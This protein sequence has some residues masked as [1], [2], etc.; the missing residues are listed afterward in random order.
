MEPTGRQRI[1]FVHVDRPAKLDQKQAREIRSHAAR[2]THARAR[3][4]R[5]IAHL[6]LPDPRQD[7]P[8]PAI[9]ESTQEEIAKDK[10]N[11]SEPMS[12]LPASRKDPFAAF[13]R[14][15]E[16][17]EHFLLDHCMSC[18]TIAA[19]H[20]AANSILADVRVVIPL[21]STTCKAF[22]SA[23]E[24][25][26]YGRRMITDW[27]PFAL[28]D[29]GL[30]SGMFLAACRDLSLSDHPRKSVFSTMALQYKLACLGAL[31]SAISTDPSAPDD[32][33]VAKVI[34]LVSDEVSQTPLVI[35]NPLQLRKC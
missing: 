35:R 33:A 26:H 12:L 15:L 31:K 25:A 30:L 20:V 23:M 11:T 7:P 2:E 32:A 3:R 29:I 24:G 9:L 22:K 14:S 1:R 16:P 28:A 5:V 18:C 4:L 21:S 6:G 10:E 13:V 19:G 34:A 27:V 17:V 8:P